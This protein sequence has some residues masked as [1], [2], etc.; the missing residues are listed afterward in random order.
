[1]NKI[2]KGFTLKTKGN[3]QYLSCD[4]IDALAGFEHGFTLRTGGFSRKPYDSLNIGLH[5]DDSKADVKRNIRSF[6]KAFGVRY[7]AAAHQVHGDKVAVVKGSKAQSPKLK[8]K[9]LEKTD[10]DAIATDVPGIAASVRVADCVGTVIVDP[11]NKVI[12][13]VHSGWRGIANKIAYKTIKEM[14]KKFKSDPAKLIAA[15]SPAIGPCCYNVGKDVYKLQKQKVFSNIFTHKGG[16]VY[17]DLWK[18]AQNLLVSAGLKRR[19]IHVCRL[20]TSDNPDMFFSHRRDEGKTGR[21]LVFGIISDVQ[22]SMRP[23]SIGAGC[24][25]TG[26]STVDDWTTGRNDRRLND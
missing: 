8:V 9:A 15:V 12:A 18:G 25:D 22:S 14:K 1:M 10:A 26:R 13:S 17:M 24:L 7:V 16:K 3:I 20:C 19:N 5:T 11:V 23:G 2:L 4:A 21:M 6:E